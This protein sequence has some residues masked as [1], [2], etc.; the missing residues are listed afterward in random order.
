MYCLAP[1]TQSVLQDP[2]KMT[3][4]LLLDMT[5][6]DADVMKISCYFFLICVTSQIQ[7]YHCGF[8]VLGNTQKILTQI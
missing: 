4:M 1:E 7:D 6:I 8:L 5:L 2:G 3:N